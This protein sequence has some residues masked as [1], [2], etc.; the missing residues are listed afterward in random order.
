MDITERKITKIAREASKLIARVTKDEPVGPSEIDFIHTVRHTPGASQNDI[1]KKLF[2]DKSVAA[3]RA[4]SLEEA[5]YIRRETN[6]DDAR[7]RLLFPT[8]KAERF[9]ISKADTET[10]FYEYLLEGLTPEEQETFAGLLDKLYI[11]SKTES[12]AGFPNVTKRLSAQ[13]DDAE[14]ETQNE[15]E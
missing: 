9:K 4:A 7:G 6:P 13:A 15:K 3:R 8:E 11:R 2:I 10:A 12:R 5:G 1:A 14:T